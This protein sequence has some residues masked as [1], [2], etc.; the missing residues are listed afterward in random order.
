MKVQSEKIIFGWML[1][2]IAIS[3][4]T[5]SSRFSDS[6]YQVS[7]YYNILKY[8]SLLP[9]LY[10]CALN[11]KSLIKM[12][13]SII[14]II[15]PFLLCAFAAVLSDFAGEIGKI[16]IFNY[17]NFI[18]PLIIFII[19]LGKSSFMKYIALSLVIFLVCSIMISFLNVNRF[20]DIGY[21]GY[22]PIRY[23]G[24]TN[25]PNSMGGISAAT[26]LVIMLYNPLDKFWKLTGYLFGGISIILSQS[27]TSILAL[28]FGITVYFLINILKK[29]PKIYV[30]GLVLISLSILS[31]LFYLYYPQLY[32]FIFDDP[33]YSSFTGRNIVWE[34]SINA[35]RLNTV[36]GYG[37]SYLWN[38][39]MQDIF[40]A[41]YGWRPGYAHSNYY[42]ILGSGGYLAILANILL[43]ISI[44]N[45]K[46]WRMI[47]FFVAIIIFRG[48]T[49][50][51]IWSSFFS[52]NSIIF[53]V[54]LIALGDAVKRRT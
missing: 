38:S 46:N 4:L 30:A 3:N 52:E 26:I 50:V 17:L 23:F 36:F 9:I 41:L 2:C 29:L 37:Y 32:S 11:L 39:N 19:F 44:F 49:E 31:S 51:T 5:S 18:V 24:I 43:V 8:A 33:E 35:W 10:Y 6:G 14:S 27:K 25:H 45:L 20:F 53:F 1:A 47:L 12:D 13:K 28:L 16:N 21:A 22:L 48:L 40:Y 42:Q 7:T 54:F 34:T 15:I